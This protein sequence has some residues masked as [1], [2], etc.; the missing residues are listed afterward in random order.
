MNTE[1]RDLTINERDAASG[2]T[3][4]DVVVGEIVKVATKL[5]A[6]VEKIIAWA[7]G[8]KY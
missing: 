7:P 2:G 8:L 1:M 3:E 4:L 6:A 5:E